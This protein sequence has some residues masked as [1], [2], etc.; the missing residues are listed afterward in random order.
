MAP[1]FAF[2]ARCVNVHLVIY[3]CIVYL[4]IKWVRT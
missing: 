4:V 1:R 2:H 3:M